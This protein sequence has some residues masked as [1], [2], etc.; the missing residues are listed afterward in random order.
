MFVMTIGAVICDAGITAILTSIISIRDQ[1]AGANN[2]RI[3]CCKRFMK[4]YMINDDL[5]ERVLNFYNYN[6]VEL[7]NIDEDDILSDLSANIRSEV[8]HFF[9]F[10]PLKE[11]Y[12]LDGFTEGAIRSLVQMMNPHLAIPGERLSVQDK[13]CTS[14][15]VLT[16]GMMIS[17]DSSGY[18]TSMPM[19]SIIGHVSTELLAKRHGLPEKALQISI[20]SAQGLKGKTGNPYVVFKVG[21]YSCRSVVKKRKEWC[22]EI[23]MK[24]PQKNVQSC[25]HIIAKSWQKGQTHS[26]IGSTSIML[27]ETSSDEQKLVIKDSQERSVGILKLRTCFHDLRKSEAVVNH[28]LTTIA[29][30]YCDLYKVDIS[31]F[32]E[33]RDYLKSAMKPALEERLIEPFI[34]TFGQQKRLSNRDRVKKYWRRPSKPALFSSPVTKRSL[35]I[36]RNAVTRESIHESKKEDITY[37]ERGFMD[38]DGTLKREPMKRLSSLL[39]GKGRKQS[40]FS[41]PGTDPEKGLLGDKEDRQ[42]WLSSNKVRTGTLDSEED[43]SQLDNSELSERDESW[44]ILVDIHGEDKTKPSRRA[45]FCVEWDPTIKG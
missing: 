1:Q 18:E 36:N 40:E 3:Q 15:F 26:T 10:K 2:R 30:G 29:K 4:T 42:S 5:Q 34:E 12:L 16:S 24:L 45:T 35:I 11:S 44:D 21:S 19:G 14:I 13:L 23:L 32:E 33:L 8:L 6:D 27:D 7:E 9:C 17:I 41:H 38:A 31:K 37:N 39:L 28:E 20:V 22:E 25:L 43:I